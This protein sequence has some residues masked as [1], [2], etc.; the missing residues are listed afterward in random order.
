MN[1]DS[2]LIISKLKIGFTDVLII[3][4]VLSMVNEIAMIILNGFPH[5][6]N[7]YLLKV[8]GGGIVY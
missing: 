1:I 3:N 7:K 5:L 6:L 2:E 8:I 4:T